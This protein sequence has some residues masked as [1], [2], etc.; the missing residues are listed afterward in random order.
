MELTI[1]LDGLHTG[2]VTL[3]VMGAPDA[4]LLTSVI[5]TFGSI[6]LLAGNGT[7]R[8][9]ERNDGLLLRYSASDAADETKENI[10]RWLLE[11][12]PL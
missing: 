5:N 7:V 12:M 4:K 1:T 2:K 11:K 10:Y 6:A 3:I 8:V 9:H